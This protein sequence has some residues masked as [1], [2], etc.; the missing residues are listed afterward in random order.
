MRPLP[1][2]F[3]LALLSAAISGSVLI[4]FGGTAWYLVYR[5]RV[6][7]LDREIRA[8][9]YRHP[10]WMGGRASPERLASAIE[11]VFG[12]DRKEQVILL[13]TDAQGAARYRSPHWPPDLDPA[14]FD[15]ELPDSPAPARADSQA[16][17]SPRRG[18]PWASGPGAGRG[19]GG[20]I[21]PLAFSKVARFQTVTAGDR[22]WRIGVLGNE[23]DRLVLGLD[24]ADLRTELGR[25]RNAFLLALTLAL[26]AIGGGGWWIAGRSVRPLR[27]IAQVAE[28]VTARG[29]NQR[30]PESNDEPEMAR[31]IQVLNGMMD[32][33]E[34]SFTQATRF[35]ADASHELKTPL[36]VMQGELEGAL[37]AAVPGS[38]EQRVF[39]NLLEQTQRLKAITRSLLLLAQA[40][41]GQLPLAAKPLDL[42]AALAEL[43]EDAEVLAGEAGVRFAFGVPGGVWVEADWPLLRQALL[44]LLQNAVRYNDPNGWIEM[45]VQTHAGRVELQLCNAGP[46][47]PTADQPRLF[48]RFFRGD[49]ARSQAV[50]GAGLGLSLAREIVR[51]HGGTLTLQESRPGRTCFALSLPALR[52]EGSPG[53][54]PPA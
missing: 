12:E 10:G 40:D 21:P 32:R 45:A 16:P 48:D 1:L 53:P 47:I 51:A 14:G 23:A 49:V 30:V 9:A 6:A 5:E 3:R 34:T 19:R 41:T 15:L 25:M 26:L 39:A 35:S 29:L 36:A 20:A 18:P 52:Q 8:L 7:A 27:T 17:P 31:L 2:R 43:K 11:F 4:A 42:S 50:D 54:P 44:N 28:R 24:C 37:Q 33:L 13:V 22:T 38:A 46:G